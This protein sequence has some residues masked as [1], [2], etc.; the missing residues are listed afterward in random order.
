VVDA[1]IEHGAH[2][3]DEAGE[4]LAYTRERVRQIEAGALAYL[5]DTSAVD[6]GVVLELVRAFRASRDEREVY[7]FCPD[8][9]EVNHG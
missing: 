3:L 4:I 9:S 8:M 1:I 7:R 5:G 2:T 6:R